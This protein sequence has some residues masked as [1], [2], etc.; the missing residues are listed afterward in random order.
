MP[1]FYVNLPLRYILRKPEYLDTIVSRGLHP[2]LGLDATAL[3]LLDQAWHRE[4]ADRLRSAGL[5]CT[6][7]LPFFDLQPGALDSRILEATRSRLSQALDVASIYGPR[8]LIGHAWYFENLHRVFF[9]TWLANS[10]DTWEGL[11][12][13]W[14]GHPPLYLENTFEPAPSPLTSLVETLAG[15]GLQSIGLCLDLGHWHCFAQGSL[16]HDLDHWLDAFAPHLRHL[17]LH[18]NLGDRDRHLGLGQGSIPWDLLFAG[19]KARNLRPTMT[20]EPHS[21][22]DLDH[23]LEFV[24]GHPEWFPAT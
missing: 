8:L 22:E 24:A 15:R 5:S 6:V 23:S 11:L 18:D 13:S 3:D 4:T 2:E 17:H 9:P 16:Q 7:H 19:L 12:R 14:P 1:S 21:A 20:L 10:A